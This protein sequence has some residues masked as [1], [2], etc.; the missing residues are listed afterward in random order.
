MGTNKLLGKL[1]RGITCYALSHPGGVVILL[2]GFI[3]RNPGQAPHFLPAVWASLSPVQIY[4]MYLPCL[5][6]NQFSG[7]DLMLFPLCLS[8]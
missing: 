3:L 8:M 5:V 1:M 4:L 6:C 7:N 2:A